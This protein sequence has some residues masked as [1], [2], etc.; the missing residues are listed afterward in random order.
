MSCTLFLNPLRFGYSSCP[1]WPHYVNNLDRLRITT[2]RPM[3]I[4]TSN[5]IGGKF[6]ELLT[7]LYSISLKSKIPRNFERMKNLHGLQH[8]IVTSSTKIVRQTLLK[9]VNMVQNQKTMTLQNLTTSYVQGPTWIEQ[10]WSKIHQCLVAYIYTQHL[11]PV[12]TKKSFS[13]R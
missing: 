3:T 6:W 11:K 2:W 8:T 9:E 1:C 7:P 4:E 10:Q 13:S 12:T 5:L